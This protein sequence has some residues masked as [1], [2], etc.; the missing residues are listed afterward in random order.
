M[1]VPARLD[2]RRPLHRVCQRQKDNQPARS[3]FD[4]T[5]RGVHHGF[6]QVETSKGMTER[7]LGMREGT[8]NGSERDVVVHV[9]KP[10]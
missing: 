4:H 5:L 8:R 3:L 10:R 1:A 7:E 9:V 2:K 6:R